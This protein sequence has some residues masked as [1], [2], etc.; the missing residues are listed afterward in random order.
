MDYPVWAGVIPM[1]LVAG[2]PLLDDK[3]RVAAVVPDYATHYK[4]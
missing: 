3:Q 1:R 4:R 2:A